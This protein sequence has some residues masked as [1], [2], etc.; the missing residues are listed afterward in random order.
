[1][2]DSVHSILSAEAQEARERWE[3]LGARCTDLGAFDDFDF[4]TGLVSTQGLACDVLFTSMG[5]ADTFA[6][7]LPYRRIGP[8]R[9][10][11]LPRFCPTSAVLMPGDHE[12]TQANDALHEALVHV[13]ANYHRAAFHLSP[14]RARR[15]TGSGWLSTSLFTYLVDLPN[16]PDDLTASWSA[17]TRRLFRKNAEAYRVTEDSLRAT[18]AVEMCAAAYNR[19]GRPLPVPLGEMGRFAANPGGSVRTRTFLATRHDSSVPEAALVTLHHGKTAYY[20][21]AGSRPG[22]GMTVLIGRTLVTLRQDG[23]RTFDFIGANTPSIAEFKRRFGPSLHEYVRLFS[24]RS[25][26]LDT[27]LRLRNR[28][29]G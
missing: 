13:S 22:P 15:A 27:I 21:I 2:S 11:I 9:E 24:S 25:R 23:I 18:T 7:L 12:T 20:W 26:L 5:G 14:D 1:M 8:F 28:I 6:A 19:S 3:R 16:T 29:R 17:G 10:I 4:V